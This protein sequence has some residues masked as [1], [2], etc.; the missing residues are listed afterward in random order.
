MGSKL[1]LILSMGIIFFA[2]LFGTDLVMIQYQYTDLDAMSTY[3][4]Y[5]LSKVA[6]IDDSILNYCEEKNTTIVDEN[7]NVSGYQKGDLFSYKLIRKYKPLVMGN[8]YFDLTISREAVI[9]IL[10]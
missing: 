4:S 8:D 5:R 9:S 1:G 2:F 10:N 7:P 3:I 6:K